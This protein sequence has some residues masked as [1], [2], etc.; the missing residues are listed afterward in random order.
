MFKAS[1]VLLVFHVIFCF[2]QVQSGSSGLVHG[3]NVFSG[4]FQ[5]PTYNPEA[6]EAK[7]YP[8]TNQASS[9][10]KQ[11]GSNFNEGKK[12]S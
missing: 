6:Y 8:S 7:N 12:I 11:Y 1:V 10:N 5:A 9:N 3:A 2:P 4:Y